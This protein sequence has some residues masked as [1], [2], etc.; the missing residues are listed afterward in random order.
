MQLLTGFLA[1]L[2]G[3]S[4]GSIIGFTNVAVPIYSDPERVG[5]AGLDQPLN[6]EQISWFGK[7]DS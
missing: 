4:Y 1:I 7:G 5:E 2:P 3:W 6:K